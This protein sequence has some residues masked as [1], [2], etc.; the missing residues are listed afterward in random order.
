MKHFTLTLFT[1]LLSLTLTGCSFFDKSDRKEKEK[2]EKTHKEVHRRI[3]GLRADMFL[4]RIIDDEG[5]D[6]AIKSKDWEANLL[7]CGFEKGPRLKTYEGNSGFDG[8]PKL[9]TYTTIFTRKGK[10]NDDIIVKYIE[11]YNYT[12]D[13]RLC[14]DEEN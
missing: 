7:A 10:D 9:R 11:E 14:Y 2:E 13:W 5:L 8:A 4:E 6:N 12:D 1:I 3:K